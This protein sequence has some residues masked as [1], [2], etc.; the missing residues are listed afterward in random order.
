M[1]SPFMG[2]F[3]N[4]IWQTHPSSTIEATV[5]KNKSNRIITFY[6]LIQNKCPHEIL[7]QIIKCMY[8]HLI[9]PRS[10]SQPNIKYHLV[11]RIWY[12]TIPWLHNLQMLMICHKSWRSGPFL[13]Y[14]LVALRDSA[15]YQS[16]DTCP[17]I[18]QIVL[19]NFI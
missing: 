5:T 8:H 1:Y 18:S 7:E 14:R 15:R 2:A 12:L 4:F 13:N 19:K 6:F 11:F 3:Y 9:C 17:P 16:Q 10:R